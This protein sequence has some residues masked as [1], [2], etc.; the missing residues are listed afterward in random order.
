MPIFKLFFDSAADFH[1]VFGRYGNVA[2]VKERVHVLAEQNPVVH[3]MRPLV[4]VRLYV[5]SFQ[6]VQ[7][8]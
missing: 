1:A 4:G 3:R 7:N 6:N 8:G 2:A 5:G